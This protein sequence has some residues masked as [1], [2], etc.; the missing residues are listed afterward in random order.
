MAKTGVSAKLG[1]DLH[2][3]LITFEVNIVPDPIPN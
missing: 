3:H 2:I 1:R